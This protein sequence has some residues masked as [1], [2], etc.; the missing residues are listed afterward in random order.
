M[1][2][3]NATLTLDLL[4]TMEPPKTFRQSAAAIAYFAPIPGP[5]AGAVDHAKHRLVLISALFL[6]VLPAV[7]WAR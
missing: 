4:G 5:D 2:R 6:L 3:K 7:A 1:K